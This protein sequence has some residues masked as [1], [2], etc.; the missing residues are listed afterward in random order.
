MGLIHKLRSLAVD[1]KVITIMIATTRVF[2]SIIRI[3][4]ILSSLLGSKECSGFRLGAIG[5]RVAGGDR[6]RPQEFRAQSLDLN[7]KLSE[8]KTAT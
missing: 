3:I 4:L 2:L 1:L 6:R 5:F 7:T 8:P